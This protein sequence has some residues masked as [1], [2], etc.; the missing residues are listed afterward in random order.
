MVDRSLLQLNNE[1]CLRN[2]L[3]EHYVSNDSGCGHFEDLDLVRVVTK[4]KL[5]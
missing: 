3:S 4:R 2:V 1:E 5:I